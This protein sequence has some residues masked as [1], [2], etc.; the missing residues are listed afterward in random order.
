M[1]IEI[2]LTDEE[3]N[4]LKWKGIREGADHNVN[5]EPFR[6]ETIAQTAVYFYIKEELEPEM[7]IEQ[8]TKKGGE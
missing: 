1:K 2:E 8:R 7:E 6:V 3:Y 4:A 5:G